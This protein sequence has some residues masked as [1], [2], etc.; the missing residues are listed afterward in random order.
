[1]KRKTMG[2]LISSTPSPDIANSGEEAAAVPSV[3]SITIPPTAP[4]LYKISQI[5]TILLL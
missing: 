5:M 2:I 4:K 3:L 1:M